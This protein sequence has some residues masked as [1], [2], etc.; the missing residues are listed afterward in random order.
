M[1]PGKLPV[2]NNASTLFER[3]VVALLHHNLLNI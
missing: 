1:E 2:P 3:M